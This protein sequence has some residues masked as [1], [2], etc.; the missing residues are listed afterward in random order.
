MATDGKELRTK[1]F[2]EKENG[3]LHLEDEEL[4][5]IFQFSDEYMYY[6]NNSKTE[7]EIVSSS[8]D[9]LIKNI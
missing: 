9:I 6:L 1:L 7:K 5:N 8:K 2:N 4:K 3:W